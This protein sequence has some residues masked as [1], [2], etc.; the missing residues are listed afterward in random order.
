VAKES[1]LNGENIG[2]LNESSRRLKE[3]ILSMYQMNNESAGG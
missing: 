3:E 1:W 2:W